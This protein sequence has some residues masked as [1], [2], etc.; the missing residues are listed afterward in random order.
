MALDFTDLDKFNKKKKQVFSFIKENKGFLTPFLSAKGGILKTHNAKDKQKFHSTSTG[1]AFYYFSKILALPPENFSATNK[2]PIVALYER[3]GLKLNS[4]FYNDHTTKDKKSQ[5]GTLPNNYNS[6]LQILGV[7]SNRDYFIDMKK[8]KNHDKY[9][10]KLIRGF[11]DNIRNGF[12]DRIGT[13]KVPS[14]YLTYW[15][16]ECIAEFDRVKQKKY[17]NTEV[18]QSIFNWASDS[19]ARSV[20]LTYSGVIQYF[21]AIEVM[22]LILILLSLLD[23]ENLLKNE[24]SPVSNVRKLIA[25]SLDIVFKKYFNNGCFTK[26]LPVFA[27]TNNFSL[28]CPTVEP[29]SLLLIQHPEY[30]IN[31]FDEMSQ[32][33]DW[34]YE[35]K[36]KGSRNSS[37]LWRSE[38]EH[39]SSSP[40]S[41]MAVS[42]YT[43]LNAFHNY[44]DLLLAEKAAVEL[45]V[46]RYSMDKSLNTYKYP[47]DLGTIVKDNIIK[48]VNNN[49]KEFAALSIVFYGPPGTSK[50]TISMKIAQDLKWP[51]LV[52]NTNT[53]LK[54]GIEKIDFEAERIFRLVSYLKNTVVLFDEVEELV[55]D[56]NPV[57]VPSDQRSRLLTT[58]MLPRI[59]DLR[60]TNRIVFIFA[61]NYLNHIDAAIVRTGRF[62]CVQCILPPDKKERKIILKAIIEKF[63]VETAIKDHIL[64]ND[65]IE[66]TDRFCYAD[67]E[68][69]VKRIVNRRSGDK[70]KS[71]DSLIEKEIAVGKGAVIDGKD[72]TKFRD[73]K[74]KFDRPNY[75]K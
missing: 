47:G 48:P 25:H 66:K 53:F 23:K 45:G 33:Y 72:L 8:D 70:N 16:V 5:T 55:L 2:E 71:I 37:W 12:I 9:I 36:F 34:V 30:L 62:D 59:N 31:H 13:S 40:T 74:E 10:E 44:I 56:R 29:I 38:W 41:F 7:L 15:V 64:G 39:P 75:K 67:L 18:A 22:Y 11:V 24:K 46:L 35:N 65:C 1:F 21:D 32:V 6:P 57:E 43:F 58:S 60:K 52:I 19:L 14:P 26:S 63:N 20:S 73:S 17:L 27:D 54:S 49:N 68:A 51:L 3:F 61:T 42:V 4:S 69:L 28:S 50:T